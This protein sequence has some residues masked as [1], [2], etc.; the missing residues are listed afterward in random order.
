MARFIPSVYL[1]SKLPDKSIRWLQNIWALGVSLSLFVTLI[2]V[3]HHVHITRVMVSM[4]FPF[5]SVLTVSVQRVRSYSSLLFGL[6]VQHSAGPIGGV[7]EYL[8]STQLGD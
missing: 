3:G 7:S 2:H 5:S 4:P 8:V 6:K 1:P